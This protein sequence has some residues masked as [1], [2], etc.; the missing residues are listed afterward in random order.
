MDVTMDEIETEEATKQDDIE[1]RASF[2]P[3]LGAYLIDIILIYSINGIILSPLKFIQDGFPMTIGYWTAIGTAGTIVYYLYFFF[4][5]KTF[6]KTVGKLIFGLKVVSA[7][8]EKPSWGDIFFREVIGRLLHNIF[9]L[10][11]LLYLYIFISDKKQGLHDV[12]GQTYVVHDI[13]K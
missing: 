3:R 1:K 7:T 13:K 2:W 12:I 4:V 5:T 11:K 10:L 9:N 6:S 8:K